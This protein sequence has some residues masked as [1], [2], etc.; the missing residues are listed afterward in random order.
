M[1]V[2]ARRMRE[3]LTPVSPVV[4]EMIRASPGTISLGQGVVSYPPPPQATEEIMRFLAAA[5]NHKYK[6]VQGIPE[7]IDLLSTKLHVENGIVLGAD[8][9]V[10]VTAGGNMAFL[11]AI[12]AIADEGDEIIL[13]SPY[14]F[15]HH[16][17]IRMSGCRP[18][19]VQT[20]SFYQPD[21][22][23]IQSAVTRRTRAVVTVSPNNPTGAVYAPSLLAAVNELCAR[24]GIFHIHDEAYEY[25]VYGNA[26]HV[27]PGSLPGAEG[28]TIS[29]FSLSKAYGFAS[30]RIGYMVIPQS[31]EAAVNKAQDTNVICPP[32]ISQYAACGAL[33]AGREF[34]RPKIDGLATTRQLVRA[35]LDTLGDVC[36]IPPADGA[37]YFL[38]KVH[39]SLKSMPLVERL[40]S[41][42]R[43]AAMPGSAFGIE[44]C[45]AIRVSYGALEPSTVAE[46]MGRLARGLRAIARSGSRGG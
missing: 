44:D 39:T 8:R 42:Y 21:P 19:P 46:G 29:L 6:H 18:V 32:V 12:L 14:Y 9:R 24:N 30:W 28:H 35:E 5:D 45:C 15:N 25:F 3:V 27:S 26:R 33:R 7:L 16:M 20:D 23:A 43:V 11:N 41:E 40:V 22:E 13:L 17:A 34:C 10:V 31:L 38:V 36:L 4:G 37:F 1:L 2:E